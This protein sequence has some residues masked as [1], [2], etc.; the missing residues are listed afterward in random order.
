QCAPW[1]ARC[2][3]SFASSR[4]LPAMNLKRFWSDEPLPFSLPQWLDWGIVAA[5][6]IACGA[7]LSSNVVDP[8][9]WGHVQ[10]GRDALQ[11]GLAGTPTFSYLDEGYP[12]VNHETLSDIYP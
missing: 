1:R 8:D 3:R 11:H 5:V 9:L 6:V 10:Y 2:A 12:R 4:R 7:V